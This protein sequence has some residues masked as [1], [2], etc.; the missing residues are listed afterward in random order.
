[1]KGASFW[2]LMVG[3]ESKAGSN[4][5]QEQIAVQ[6]HYMVGM[7]VMWSKWGAGITG[8][9]TTTGAVWARNSMDALRLDRKVSW[10]LKDHFFKPAEQ[11][12]A[13][14]ASQDHVLPSPFPVFYS[15]SR[16]QE[17]SKWVPCPF[18][19][20]TKL[21]PLRSRLGEEC[22]FQGVSWRRGQAIVLPVRLQTASCKTTPAQMLMLTGLLSKWDT[23][24]E[25]GLL[26]L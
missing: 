23:R 20:F 18:K 4:Y 26:G 17:A 15:W 24:M 13:T 10:K 11:R 22:V 6:V 14:W 1:M 8:K 7:S 12:G 5:L 19:T 3:E 16:S 2:S 25:W 21:L 9:L